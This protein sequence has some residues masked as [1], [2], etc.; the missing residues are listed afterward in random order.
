MH[1]I[2]DRAG[3]A[4]EDRKFTVEPVELR[5]DTDGLTFEGV[6]SSVDNPYTVHD[7]FGEFE[8]TI[9][10]GAFDKT[11]A[12]RD[13]V[14]LL[15]NHDGIPLA[16]TKSK[17]LTL[18]TNPHL[19]AVATLDADNPTVRE[20]RSAMRRGD[21]DQMSIGFRVTRQEWNG[22]YTERTIREVKLFDVSVVTYPA[23]PATSA[24][25]RS[26]LA[27]S[28]SIADPEELRA[29][30]G[31]LTATLERLD[32][33]DPEPE[34]VSADI[35]ARYARLRAHLADLALD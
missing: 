31:Q 21:L 12:E 18:S 9:E 29:A 1:T 10:R 23:N 32:P 19:R 20:V 24:S 4:R 34:F 27:E 17:T 30:I 16:R 33:R 8:E 13:D 6:A 22:D 14:R 15:V 5:D 35:E 7:M 26:L 28:S 25:L 2:E 11:L 3:L